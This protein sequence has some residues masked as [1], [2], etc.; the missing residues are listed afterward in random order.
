MP[1]RILPV[2]A[3]KTP[4]PPGKIHPPWCWIHERR[5]VY[6]EGYWYCPEIDVDGT[7]CHMAFPDEEARSWQVEIL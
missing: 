3:K 5:L 4:L 2:R 6:R 1:R 7:R